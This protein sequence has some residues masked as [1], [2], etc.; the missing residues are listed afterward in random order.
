MS[1]GRAGGRCRPESPGDRGAATL[2][3][4]ALTGFLL[5]LGLT[6]ASVAGVV[7]AHRSAQAAADLAALAGAAAQ[8][9][10]ESGCPAAASVATANGGRLSA[11]DPQGAELYVEVVVDGPGFWGE[12]VVDLTGR[13]RAGPAIT[14][15]R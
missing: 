6:L 4:V 9:R 3:I 7:G 8:A 1:R 10:G 15:I 5:T 2:L 12:G 11:C 14:A 13:A